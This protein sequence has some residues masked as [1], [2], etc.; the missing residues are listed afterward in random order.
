M[1]LKYNVY[2]PRPKTKAEGGQI[3]LFFERH[4]ECITLCEIK[5]TNQH[6]A[7]D[8]KIMGFFLKKPA[9]FRK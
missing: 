5:Y 8:K 6:F 2:F 4:D 9:H 7:M 1:I 3:D